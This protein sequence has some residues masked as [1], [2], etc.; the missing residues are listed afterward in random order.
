MLRINIHT[1][2]IRLNYNIENAQLNLQTTPPKLEME[3]TPPKLEI[4][5]P[6]GELTIDQ[7]DYRYSIGL[8]TIADFARDN[9]ELGKQALRETVARIIDEGDQM[10]RIEVD[11]NPIGEAAF[12]ASVQDAPGFVWAR[13]APPEI[14]YQAKP[15]EINVIEGMISY[16]L[17]RGKVDSE[18]LP[19]RVDIRVLQYSSI[20]YST[21]DVKV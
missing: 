1:Q 20:Q 7:T 9:A 3:S 17:Q 11:Y 5:Q 15:A 16:S 6:W 14:H 12:E 4:R 2:P 18:Y 21:I 19:G 10:A 13:T 8:K